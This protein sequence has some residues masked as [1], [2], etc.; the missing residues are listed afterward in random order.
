M[1]LLKRII[2]LSVWSLMSSLFCL[3]VTASA[4][5]A[6]VCSQ[7]ATSDIFTKDKY[8][9]REVRIESP[10]DFLHTVTS[11]LNA[12]KSDLPLRKGMPFSVSQLNDGLDLINKKLKEADTNG[13]QLFRLIVVRPHIERCDV[14]TRPIP[15]LDVV[16]RVFT[17][18]YNSYLSHTFELKQAEVEHPAMASATSQ[19]KGFL[20]VRPQIGY[21]R[22]RRLF[23]GMN[24]KMRTP[25][26]I[27]DT[28]DFTATG[29]NDSNFEELVLVGSRE[30]GKSLLSHLEY[31]LGYQHSDTPAD[32]IRLRSGKLSAQLFGA[33]EPLG[34]KGLVLRFGMSLEGGNQQTNPKAAVT[35]S[36]NLSNSGYGSLKAYA[37]LTARSSYPKIPPTE[38]S[39]PQITSSF[40]GSYGL[41]AG[42]NGASTSI[43]FIKHVVDLALTMRFLPKE[44]SAQTPGAFHKTLDLEAQF[45]GGVIQ[46]L[47]KL[48]VVESFF[49]GNAQQEFITGDSWHIRS[50][51]FIRS[52]P[53]NR[54]NALATLAPLGGTK[55]YSVNITVARPLWGR[56][57]LPKELITDPQFSEKLT[58]EIRSQRQILIQ[59]YKRKLRDF[60]ELLKILPPL[61]AD[62]QQL[63]ALHG[64]LTAKSL[65]A[66]EDD[67]SDLSDD[68]SIAED[69]LQ[70]T[71]TT[72]PG[73]LDDYVIGSSSPLN[74]FINHL[75]HL[76]ATLGNINLATEKAQVEVIR[77]S[78]VQQQ[79]ALALAI[80]GIPV[81][82]AEKQADEALQSLQP[83]V[84]SLFHELNII[85]V[86]PVGIFDA[87]RIWPDKYG[88]RF[89][90]GGGVRL[91]LVNFN[92]T[93]GYA[94]NPRPRAQE[95]RGAFFFSMDVTDLFR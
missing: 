60:K 3:L 20:L 47:G 90:I 4:T 59:A 25:G 68:L 1:L 44:V 41:Q 21:N 92:V 9:V 45:T 18:N 52:F 78:M 39:A 56:A 10:F 40:T 69:A 61:E 32:S 12:I 43:D 38:I 89:G 83:I 5:K 71:K 74:Q 29:S 76:I 48:P 72:D 53:Q 17:T 73:K 26:G 87:A 33:S 65:A 24:V 28:L 75:N 27:F 30:P 66:L 37:G 77:T 62:L 49:G 2:S 88:T 36:N 64:K 84:Q 7:P 14:E 54:L 93:L 91:T 51:P 50:T 63:T 15:E 55:F 22:T 31:R 35:V 70:K 82:Q 42:T 58:G 34:T 79:D 95:G 81:K 23:G 57:I 86:S 16:Y 13:D 19:A 8:R 80:N 11:S 46:K 94:V 6:Q 67:L 85:A